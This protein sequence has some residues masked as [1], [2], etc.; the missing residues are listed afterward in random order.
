MVDAGATGGSGWG[1]G[2]GSCL[3]QQIHDPTIPLCSLQAHDGEDD[4]VR[5]ILPLGWRTDEKEEHTFVIALNSISIRGR[6]GG[7]QYPAC[8]SGWCEMDEVGTQG[9][10]DE[11]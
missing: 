6:G 11:K 4:R 8:W 2:D 3:P 5:F 1:N 9:Q 7:I 10:P